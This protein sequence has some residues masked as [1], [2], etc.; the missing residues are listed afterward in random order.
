MARVL[1][2]VVRVTETKSLALMASL[3][4]V[5]IC[6]PDSVFGDSLFLISPTVIFLSPTLFLRSLE[7]DNTLSILSGLKRSSWRRDGK[8]SFG[9]S[10]YQSF[11]SLENALVII[12]AWFWRHSSVDSQ[13]NLDSQANLNCVTKPYLPLSL[14]SYIVVLRV[15]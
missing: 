4:S 14:D 6:T 9:K 13:T 2:F 8:D 7:S 3:D 1:L 10:F 5:T 15:Q 11:I 12:F